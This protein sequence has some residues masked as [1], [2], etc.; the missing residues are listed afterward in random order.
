MKTPGQATLQSMPESFEI[1]DDTAEHSGT[2]Y[3]RL[4]LLGAT[5][6]DNTTGITIDGDGVNLSALNGI[7]PNGYP[8]N[9]KFTKVTLTGGVVVASKA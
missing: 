2:E 5:F 7:T 9:G 3:S 1:I 8:L 4:S 6:P